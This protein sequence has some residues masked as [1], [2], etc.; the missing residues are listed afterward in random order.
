MR[1]DVPPSA[2]CVKFLSA[3]EERR[4]Q[5]CL[6]C[7][8]QVSS[9]TQIPTVGLKAG[10]S[11]FCV[12]STSAKHR[13]LPCD[14]A[15]IGSLLLRRCHRDTPAIIIAHSVRRSERE[16][17][18]CAIVS[19]QSRRTCSITSLIPPDRDSQCAAGKHHPSN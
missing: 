14:V 7:Q 10:S 8:L 5:I 6:M 18:T 15:L 3:L 1:Y 17:D 19:H 11:L 16:G 2:L 9:T 13:K 4:R 12:V